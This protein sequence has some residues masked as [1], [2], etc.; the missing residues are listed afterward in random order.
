MGLASEA[1]QS[2]S[3]SPTWNLWA[4]KIS[5]CMHVVRLGKPAR[6]RYWFLRIYDV[7]LLS[8]GSIITTHSE[9]SV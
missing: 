8:E 3:L 5:I 4:Q 2:C 9:V 1:T 7:L 6:L